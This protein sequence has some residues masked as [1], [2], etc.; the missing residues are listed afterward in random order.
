MI[1]SNLINIVLSAIL[2]SRAAAQVGQ[3][4]VYNSI[5]PGCTGESLLEIDTAP[6][7]FSGCE[8]V[9]NAASYTYSLPD[10]CAVNIYTDLN[11]ADLIGGNQ[12]PGNGCG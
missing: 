5:N 6:G 4:V 10:G 9:I 11:C 1:Y 7:A 8:G 2:F 12:G 3:V